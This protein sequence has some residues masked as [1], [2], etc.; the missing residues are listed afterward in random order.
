MA[1]GSHRDASHQARSPNVRMSLFSIG[2]RYH[3]IAPAQP[4]HAADR[5]AHEIVG[6]LTVIAARGG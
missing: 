2:M 3:T 5:C 6:I 4:A 1:S